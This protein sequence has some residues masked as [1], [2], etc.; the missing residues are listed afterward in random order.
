MS[1]SVVQLGDMVTQAE[2][3]CIAEVTQGNL[4]VFLWSL[5]PLCWNWMSLKHFSEKPVFEEQPLISV[6]SGRR[7]VMP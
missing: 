5:F 3:K 1:L 7:L 6:E 4:P 2:L